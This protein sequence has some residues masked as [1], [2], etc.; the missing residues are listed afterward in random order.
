MIERRRCDHGRWFA[1]DAYMLAP[2]WVIATCDSVRLHAVVGVSVAV[3]V[4]D[5]RRTNGGMCQ[6][7]WPRSPSKDKAT[8][9]YGDA[10]LSALLRSIT[11]DG[12]SLTDLEAWVFGG[13][14]PDDCPDELRTTVRAS[15][16]IARDMLSRRGIDIIREDVG[17]RLGRKIAFDLASGQALVLSTRNLRKRDWLPVIPA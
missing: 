11:A 8:A 7:L 1:R 16:Q 15:L 9:R 5:R 4:R 13:A 2:G 17:G 12:S 6:Y 3:C 14:L 10:A